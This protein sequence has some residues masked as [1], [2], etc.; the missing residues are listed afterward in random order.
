MSAEATPKD[1]NEIKGQIKSKWGKLADTDAESF[2]GNMHLIVER[3]QK[4]Y[5][6][7]KDK[8]EIE[9]ADFKKTLEMKASEPASVKLV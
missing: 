7:T 2:K 9:Y 8:A 5:G 6:L 3:V 4:V 1:W